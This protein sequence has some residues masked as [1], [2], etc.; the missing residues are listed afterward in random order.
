MNWT[1]TAID[2]NVE[3]LLNRIRNGE[4]EEDVL[5]GL[6]A[7]TQNLVKKL[8]KQFPSPKPDT[9]NRWMESSPEESYAVPAGKQ[10]AAW[11]DANE[12][13]TFMT[14]QEVVDSAMANI[15]QFY[16]ESE[17]PF[18]ARLPETA[19]EAWQVIDEIWSGDPGG[20]GWHKR[21]PEGAGW[22]TVRRMEGAVP[23][24]RFKGGQPP[25]GTKLH[26]PGY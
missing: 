22:L 18:K 26:Q 7:E 24:V 1:R 13:L 25:Q 5:A 16:S 8:M 4:A 20:R 23:E 2:P 9:L 14:D 10:W 3:D 12:I 15:E 17:N 19:D 21:I 6:P 11:D